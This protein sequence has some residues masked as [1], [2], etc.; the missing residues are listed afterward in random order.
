MSKWFFIPWTI[1]YLIG[2]T[3]TLTITLPIFMSNHKSWSY[4]S[5]AGFGLSNAL[6]CITAFL[7]RNAPDSELSA[8]FF[9]IDLFFGSI[10]VP[11]LLLMILF[12]WKEKILY[13][14]ITLPG[15]I[16]AGY[17]LLFSPFKIIW[18]SLGW[19][20]YF[21]SPFNIIFYCNVS[22]Y[23]FVC[24]IILGYFLKKIPL[25]ILRKKYKIII[26][27]VTLLAFFSL[28]TS[29]IGQNIKNFPPMGGIFNIILFI[30]ISS[31]ISLREE[32][33]KTELENVYARFLSGIFN[34][35]PGRELGQNLIEF[36][37]YID[38]T[39][40]SDFVSITGDSYSFNKNDFYKTN[41]IDILKKN[42]QYL[43]RH[44]NNFRKKISSEFRDLFSHIYSFLYAESKEETNRE[45]RLIIKD[46][47][48]FLLE[49]NALYNLGVSEFLEM[50]AEDTLCGRKKYK[51]LNNF[52]EKLRLTLNAYS[53]NLLDDRYRAVFDMKKKVNAGLSALYKEYNILFY[54]RYNFIRGKTAD[55]EE[56]FIQ[57]TSQIIRLH[58]A[59]TKDLPVIPVFFIERIFNEIY[60]SFRED[61]GELS[62]LDLIKKD[63]LFKHIKQSGNKIYFP[64]FDGYIHR[65][66]L[67]YMCKVFAGYLMKK[68]SEKYLK[69][70]FS[71]VS[72]FSIPYAEVII[73]YRQIYIIKNNFDLGYLLINEFTKLGYSTLYIGKEMDMPVGSKKSI[74]IEKTSLLD[75][76]DYKNQISFNNLE[77]LLR[78]IKK[79]IKENKDT[80]IMLNSID[81]MLYINSFTEV[82][83][84][85]K[86]IFVLIKENN[87]RLIIPGNLLIINEK[88]EQILKKHFTILSKSNLFYSCT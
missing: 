6:W 44:N 37:Q 60:S 38:Y 17:A 55:F 31:A 68:Y 54:D 7:H 81:D 86:R 80:V 14:F 40:M 49:S 15:F 13:I 22:G 36:T 29:M 43:E 12:L 76:L 83:S 79:Y 72:N 66:R 58:H 28:V 10:A 45:F 63:T 24:L 4:R 33:I 82:I 85:L 57:L 23:M 1:Q 67:I 88:E 48:K 46:H 75:E 65:Q 62:V 5:F 35:F 30:F 53:K 21:T 11:F 64:C 27:G 32:R 39:G 52:Y 59:V 78:I 9:R 19:N 61:T 50:I 56:G 41:L 71:I 77:G 8:L 42:I 3:V 47:K 51:K 73:E 70:F 2:A 16:T 84:L 26:T 87:A 20:Y 69:L 34:A 25:M 74:K 18:S